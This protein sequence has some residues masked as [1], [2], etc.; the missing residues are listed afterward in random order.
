MMWYI[1]DEHDNPIAEPDMVLAARWFGNNPKR[2]IVTKTD[3]NED[4]TLST[5]FLGLDHSYRGGEPILYESM[6]FGG[7][8]NGD[9]R[10][11]NTKK[12]AFEGH[13]EMLGEVLQVLKE[14]PISWEIGLNDLLKKK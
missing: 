11:Y 4:C 2:R 10:R 5:V 14:S 3:V 9:M 1:L 13:L 6:W 12:E 7:P 8:N